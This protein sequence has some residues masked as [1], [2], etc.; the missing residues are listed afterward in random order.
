MSNST[1]S[2]QNSSFLFSPL[3][4]AHPSTFPELVY[5]THTDPGT[6]IANLS[7]FFGQFYLPVNISQIQLLACKTLITGY[8]D[9][10]NSPLISSFLHPPH[11][12]QSN[13][14]KMHPQPY[15]LLLK[16]T[17]SAYPLEQSSNCLHWSTNG[18]CTHSL[19]TPKFYLLL[20]LLWVIT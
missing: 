15:H 20:L 18:Q 9:Y 17:S 6:A 16:L 14:S 4:H 7:L 5:G 3:K 13:L 2:K 12:G 10:W 1:C 19:L 11:F 8:E